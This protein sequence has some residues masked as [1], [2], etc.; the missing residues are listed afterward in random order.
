MRLFVAVNLSDRVRAAIASCL[1]AF[2]LREPPW[3]W[4]AIENLH[5]TLKFIGE[6]EERAVGKVEEYVRRGCAGTGSFLMEFSHFGGFP[7]LRR[8]RVLFFAATGGADELKELAE[9]VE[10]EICNGL[11]LAREKRAFKPH[12]T[13]ARIKKPL[14]QEALEALSRVPP[15]QG[16]R[17]EVKAVHLMQST[18]TRNGAVYTP[19]KEIALVAGR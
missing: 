15:L 12:V 2:P 16:V 7:D 3:R 13:V 5:I 17:Q 8:P 14:S 10:R 11:G 18:L 9:R 1:E 6:V 4:V 19:L